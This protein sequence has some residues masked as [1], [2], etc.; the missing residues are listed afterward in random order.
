[1]KHLSGWEAQPVHSELYL[2]NPSAGNLVM[3]KSSSRT[4]FIQKAQIYRLDDAIN[5]FR[6][7]LRGTKGDGAP[8]W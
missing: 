7:E 8:L 2:I 5:S 3:F 6:V 1:M 4:L